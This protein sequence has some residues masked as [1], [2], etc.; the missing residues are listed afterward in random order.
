MFFSFA[1]FWNLALVGACEALNGKRC[2]SCE[3]R[4]KDGLE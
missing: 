4:W 3:W 2:D 1:M